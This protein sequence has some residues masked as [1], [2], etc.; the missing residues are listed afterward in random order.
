MAIR[1]NFFSVV[2][3]LVKLIFQAKTA[4][5]ERNEKR[6][7]LLGLFFLSLVCLVA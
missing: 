3:R 7:P 6:L 1:F 2:G 4:T 5:L